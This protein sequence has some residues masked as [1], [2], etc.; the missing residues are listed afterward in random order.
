MEN[1]L[2]K[3]RFLSTLSSSDPLEAFCL[4]AEEY[5]EFLTKGELATLGEESCAAMLRSQN[6]GGEIEPSGW[7]DDYSLFFL[8][9]GV[10][11]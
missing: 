4:L 9:L 3:E 5:G 7:N 6:G 10:K 8:T 2:I 11:V 1:P